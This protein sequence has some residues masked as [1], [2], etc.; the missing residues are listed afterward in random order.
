[1]GMPTAQTATTT[2]VVRNTTASAPKPAGGTDIVSVLGGITNAG[3]FASYLRT[4]GVVKTLTGAGPYTVFAPT[5]SSFALL[6]KGS[7]SG[8]G[9]LAQK[10]LVE[11]HVVSGKLLDADAVYSGIYYALSR[12]ALNFSVPINSGKVYINSATVVGQYKASNGI[13]YMISSVLFPP[14]ASVTPTPH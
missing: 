1:M 6:A 4:T 10:R 12:D 13:V 14:T 9:A 3:T 5:D 11:Y 8:L 7:I 2:P